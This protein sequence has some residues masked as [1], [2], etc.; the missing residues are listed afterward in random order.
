MN[1]QETKRNILM[2]IVSDEDNNNLLNVTV[3]FSS[4]NSI[5]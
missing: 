4:I 1:L 2:V 3:R 5:Y